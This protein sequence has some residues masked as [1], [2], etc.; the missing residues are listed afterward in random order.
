[1]WSSINNSRIRSIPAY[2]FLLQLV[3]AGHGQFDD[4]GTPWHRRVVPQLATERAH[5][6]A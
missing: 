6:S 5:K 2:P 3:G 4:K 1:M